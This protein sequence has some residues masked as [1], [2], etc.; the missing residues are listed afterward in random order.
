MDV[1]VS[2][3]VRH[4]TLEHGGVVI[5]DMEVGEWL[6]LNATAGEFWRAWDA[7]AP[8][9]EGVLRV[10]A[11]N[12]GV[13][14]DALRADAARLIAELAA[15]GLITATTEVAGSE[16]ARAVRSQT[17]SPP[18]AGRSA[19]SSTRPCQPGGPS[20]PWLPP[21]PSGSA[22]MA[23]APRGEARRPGWLRGSLALCFLAVACLVTRFC[24]FRVALWLVRAT[25]GGWFR[26]TWC[27][28]SASELE[29]LAVVGAV[30]W[31]ARRY[32]GRAA[33]L[34]QSLAAVL[35]AAATRRRLDWCLGAATDPYRFHAWV[36]AAGRPVWSPADQQ[37]PVRYVRVLSA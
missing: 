26:L 6:A 17:V 14:V 13:S 4:E 32:P 2:G 11:R 16:A 21:L 29:A 27:R 30:A 8:F 15:R 3:H 31:A 23:E 12:P 19:S 33:C 20:A 22:L 10:A 1:R 36:E 25:R 7:G 24:G 37:A 34:E 28:R 35:L 5:L 9:E 18:P